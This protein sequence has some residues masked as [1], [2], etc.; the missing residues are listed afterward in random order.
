MPTA[1]AAR[2]RARR[3]GRAAT[4]VDVA[5]LARV[6]ANT[7]S[8]VLNH[9]EQVAPET[10]DR[11]NEAIRVTGYV[12]NLLAAGV[13]SARS[14]LVAAVVPTVS[15]PMFLETI[16]AL[17]ETLDQNG[18]Q[19]ILGQGGYD[20]SREDEL[21]NA[22]IGRRP[23]G[24]AIVGVVH[25]PDS[26]RR[27]LASHIPIV[28]MWDLTPTPVDMVVGFA[29]E[30]IGASV[31][32]FLLERGRMRLAVISGRDGRAARRSR[33][34]QGAAKKQGIEAPIE[35][36]PAPGTLLA[37]REA[38]ARL[39]ARDDRPDAIFCSSDLVALGAVTRPTL[40][41][42]PSPRISPW[43]ASATSISPRASFRRSP[44]CTSTARAS[45]VSPPPCWSTAP[46]AANRRARRSMSASPSS[47]APAP[48][49]SCGSPERAG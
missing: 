16:Q 41:G 17:T 36:I 10:R 5:R 42:S 8:R 23:A 31:C 46:R 20:G 47:S 34:F 28:E 27:L 18:Y 44:L 2:K 15:G 11:V 40:A 22:I 9:P 29:H 39:L 13:R 24:I 19:L 43:S 1:A 45:D 26:R 33:A 3:A 49:P 21:L 35:W 37:G 14:K 38:A 4:V 48:E 7:V 6:A 12:P 32:D 25:S 30:E